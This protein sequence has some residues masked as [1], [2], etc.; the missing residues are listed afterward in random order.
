MQE[1]HGKSGSLEVS[2]ADI[3][4]PACV[5]QDFRR[6]CIELGALGD[7]VV[8]TAKKT[9]AFLKSL[10]DKKLPFIQDRTA[11]RK[12]NYYG[13]GS[14]LALDVDDVAS[15]ATSYHAMRIRGKVSLNDDGSGSHGGALNTVTHGGV[16]A[17]R[18]Q[19]GRGGRGRGEMAAAPRTVRTAMVR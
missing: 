16:R 10:P 15:R 4:D 12:V 6:I 11:V 3:C 13:Y 2:A 8:P 7:K 5:I 1:L 19:G 18:K 9:H 17:F 14:C